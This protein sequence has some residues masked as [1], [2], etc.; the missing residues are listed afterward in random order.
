MCNSTNNS[1]STI[2][3]PFIAVT[4]QQQ[5]LSQRVSGESFGHPEMD[6]DTLKWLLV[7]YIYNK[8]DTLKSQFGLPGTRSWLRAW[9]TSS[10]CV[11]SQ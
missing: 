1:V 8:M 6:L 4:R 10:K 2:N 9:R 7:L 5:G 3:T 11:T